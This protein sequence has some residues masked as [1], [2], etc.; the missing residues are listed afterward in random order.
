[1]SQPTTQ[2]ADA[3]RVAAEHIY[4]LIAIATGAVAVAVWAVDTVTPGSSVPHEV[5]D[6]MRLIVIL[7][8]CGYLVRSAESRV[9][10]RIERRSVEQGEQH[11]QGYAAG[12]VDG[13]TGRGAEDHS[14]SA[15][16]RSLH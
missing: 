14:H 3:P 16:V 8:G 11:R 9:E 13:A 1:M 2:D 5:Y 7:A 10:R 4:L 12:F 15:T 6:A